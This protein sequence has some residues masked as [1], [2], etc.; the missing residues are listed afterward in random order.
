MALMQNRSTAALLASSLLLTIGRGATL[1]FMTIYLNRQYGMA[2]DQVGYAMTIALTIGVIFSLGFG[3]LA[4][5]FDKKRYMVLAILAFIAGFVAIPLSHHAGLV[6]LF[7]ALINCAYSVFSTVLKAYFSDTLSAPAKT[8]VFSLNY[9]VLNIG[10]TVGPPLGTLLV[11]HSINLPFL[12][13]AVCAAFPLVFIQC[14]V[15]RVAVSSADG[16]VSW[17][18][19]VL[20]KDRAL[21]WF[22]LSNVLASFV[23]GTFASCLSQYVMAVASSDFAEKVVAVI[24]PVNAAIVVSLQYAVGRKLTPANLRPLMAVGTLCFVLGLYGFM[25]SGS[26]L[27]L[28]AAATAVFTLGEIIYA[29]GE[30]MLIDHIAPPGMKATYFSAQALGWFGAAVNPLFTGMILTTLPPWSLFVIL[31]ILIVLAWLMMLRGMRI[32]CWGAVTA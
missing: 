17:S 27:W 2:V 12:L 28:W 5:K 26:N 31:S 30:Y 22:T 10:W 1:P 11:M 18:P 29:P 7:F 8:K 6:V 21:G 16:A 20:I 14:F 25:L 13:A 3:M 23:C 19:S 15:Q 4:D 24:L 32:N 9:T